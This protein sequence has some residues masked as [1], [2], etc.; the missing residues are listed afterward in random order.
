MKKKKLLTI[1]AW[2]AFLC[3]NVNQVVAQRVFV[4]PGGL[5]NQADLDRMKAKVAAME[6]PW[7]ES[8][9][10]LINDSKAQGAHNAG[11]SANIGGSGPRQRAS[12]DAHVAYVNTLRWY[13]SGDTKYA[14]CAVRICNSWANTV[15]EVASGELFQLPIN[16]FMQAAE[17]LRI[18]PGWSAADQAKFKTMA[19]QYFYPACH[20]FLG[21]CGR[22][23]SWDSPAAAS[24]MGIAVFCEDEAKFDEAV[25]YYK[26]GVGN[27]SLPNAIFQS[28]GQ[29][30]EMGRDQPHATIGPAC[31]AE[32]A[33]TAYNQGDESLYAYLDNRLL[34]GFEYYC[35]F[36]LNHKD[37]PWAYWNNCINDNFSYI[38]GSADANRIR[39][40]PVYEMLYN[41][42]HV[43]KGLE[44]PYVKAMAELARPEGLG[45]ADFF[46]G[47]TLYYTLDGDKS[48]YKPHP[49]P[50]APTELTAT[51]GV[52]YI[53]LNW[54]APSGDVAQGYRIMRSNRAT[55]GFTQI[56]T[57]DNNTSAEYT[58]WSVADLPNNRTY[59]YTVSAINQSGR[60]AES[61]AANTMF[62]AGTSD[63]PVGWL[64]KEIGG[65]DAD[66]SAIYANNSYILNSTG[67]GIDGASDKIRYV[68]TAVSGDVTITA[69]LFNLGR[70]PRQG[71]M[72]RETID[73]TSK[74]VAMTMGR[75]DPRFAASATRINQGSNPTWSNGNQFSKAPVWFRIK[76]EGNTFTVYES[77]NGTN[78]Y[79][80]SSRTVAMGNSCYV[81]IFI[82][83]TPTS[84]CVFDNVSVEGG[85]D[86]PA[87]PANVSAQAMNSSRIKLSWTASSGASGY[88]LKRSPTENGEYTTIANGITATNYEDSGLEI[89]T[90]YFYILKAMNAKGESANSEKVNAKTLA[91]TVPP[92]PGNLNATNGNFQVA[93]VWNA[94]EELTTIYNIKRSDVSGGPYSTI[95]TSPVANYIDATVENNQTYY[96]VVTAV[97]IL[98]ESEPANEVAANPS[99]GKFRYYPLDETTGKTATD[100][101]NKRL[102]TLASGTAWVAGKFNNGLQFDGSSNAYASLPAGL[103]TTVKSFTVSLWVNLNTAGTWTR[104]FDFGTGESYYLFLSAK[105]SSGALRFAIKN[106]ASE[107]TVDGT[108]TLPLNQ[109]VHIAVTLDWNDA[110][111]IGVAKLYVNGILEGTNSTITINPSMLPST[112][113]NYIGKSQYSDPYLKGIVD[114][115]RIY[116]QALNAEQIAQ[117]KNMGNQTITFEPFPEKNTND[118]DFD[119]GA[120]S[121]S[122]LKIAYASSNARV[123]RIVD[124][125]IKI[126]DAGTAEITASQDGEINYAAAQPVV[127]TLTVVTSIGID[128]RILDADNYLCLT[129]T[130]EYLTIKTTENTLFLLFSINGSLLKTLN[131]I[132]GENQLDVKGLPSGAYIGILSTKD[133]KQSFKILK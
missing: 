86:A 104:L 124:G 102:A 123:A 83:G 47:G 63:L 27:G 5:L 22:P 12:L 120:I 10:L 82:G 117:L 70:E 58:D 16:N 110:S 90:D 38:A 46:G 77:G 28:T 9:N 4:H 21:N 100:I 94:T 14:D 92:A 115:F 31:L 36:N 54:T 60:G 96:Y 41:Y 113:Q 67:T 20:N 18:Y 132:E 129:S 6:S 125:K 75:G 111:A 126:T 68:Y 69:R 93:L 56:A 78:W 19:L 40:S 88:I 98:G 116:N 33:Q 130:K 65:N 112:N 3:I 57:W 66:G 2:I 133:G 114:E 59:Y 107:Q 99:D 44:T 42:Y 1:V 34:A 50:A 121:S 87:A 48:P 85:G 91:L 84:T 101:W 24:I 35:K 53:R 97:N 29:I 72:L 7:I 45:D 23:A 62:T 131:C 105:N 49:V 103:L 61:A 128:K 17:L 64:S 13:I 43:K 25:N 30:A 26:N 11:P 119:P 39:Q 109:W 79:A 95:G 106:G 118:A 71:V 15:S 55:G 73:P 122:G 8:W 108:T 37:V 51:P 74:M 32:M 76:R 52:S 80:V 127:R 89:N 81:G